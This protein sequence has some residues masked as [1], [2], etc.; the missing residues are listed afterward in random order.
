MFRDKSCIRVS[1]F[2]NWFLPSLNRAWLFLLCFPFNVGCEFFLLSIRDAARPS[3]SEEPGMF[4]SPDTTP[5]Q[6]KD[7]SSLPLYGNLLTEELNEDVAPPPPPPPPLTLSAVVFNDPPASFSPPSGELKAA[8]L[9][10]TSGFGV[11]FLSSL[12]VRFNPCQDLSSH[13]N[14]AVLSKSKNT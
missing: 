3:S 6:A 14:S 5:A 7:F 11:P 12:S 9:L 8:K 2:S 1:S 13:Y 4:L 10:P